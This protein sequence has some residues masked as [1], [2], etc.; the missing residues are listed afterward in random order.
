MEDRIVTNSHRAQKLTDSTKKQDHIYSEILLEV[1]DILREIELHL[2]MIKY[3][4]FFCS[5]NEETIAFLFILINNIYLFKYERLQSQERNVLR[6]MYNI[7]IEPT[8]TYLNTRLKSSLDLNEKQKDQ[9]E[10]LQRKNLRLERE[11]R[12]RHF[13]FHS[14]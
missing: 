5:G 12:G 6:Q 13:W 8:S 2:K 1:S 4:S 7:Q 9:L 10:E 3:W 11:R 14:G